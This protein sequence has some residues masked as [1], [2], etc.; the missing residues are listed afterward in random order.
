M[1]IRITMMM[2]MMVGWWWYHLFPQ[3]KPMSKIAWALP[4]SA[5]MKTFRTCG[6]S[7]PLQAF[8]RAVWHSDSIW[9]SDAPAAGTFEG[10]NL[11]TWRSKASTF[12]ADPSP[13][14]LQEIDVKSAR[15]LLLK[16]GMHVPITCDKSGQSFKF[17]ESRGRMKKKNGR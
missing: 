17:K 12:Q 2:M 14:G 11:A 6:T 5:S 3:P 16:L 9:A 1:I 13:R 7:T 8:L 4:T 15:L 10:S